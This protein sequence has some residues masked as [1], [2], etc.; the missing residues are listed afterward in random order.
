MR[1]MLAVFVAVGLCS[2]TARAEDKKTER[3]WKAKC[4]SCHGVDG[5]GDTETGKKAKIADMT[6]PEWHKKTTDADIREAILNGKK[7]EGGEMDPFKDKLS[8]EQVDALV[9][10]LHTLG[11][12]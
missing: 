3:L 8:S 12:K 5:K 4:A 6:T 1:I 7:V 2:A 11:S 9:N 10:Y